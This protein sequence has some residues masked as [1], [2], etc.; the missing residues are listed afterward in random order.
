[1][2]K[3]G[4]SIDSQYYSMLGKDA[5]LPLHEASK[6]GNNYIIRIL[7]SENINYLDL[8]DKNGLT[9]LH[10]AALFSKKK[11]YHLLLELGAKS[12]VI[13]SF[14]RTPKQIFEKNESLE[15]IGDSDS[16]WDSCIIF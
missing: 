11:S 12:D 13:D 8:A 6:Q 1:M 5:V 15:L 9:P 2:S 3:Y 16:C 14:G 7:V 10:Y 4:F